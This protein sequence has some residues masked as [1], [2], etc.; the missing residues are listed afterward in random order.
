MSIEQYETSRNQYGGNVL[1]GAKASMNVGR[2][3]DPDADDE[4]L[5][6]LNQ[7]N[8]EYVRFL[9]PQQLLDE[10]GGYWGFN[11]WTQTFSLI[12]LIQ[13]DGFLI[14]ETV[15]KIPIVRGL[16]GLDKMHFAVAEGKYL[17]RS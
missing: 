9:Q 10:P 4:M 7:L 6:Y 15:E 3:V 11:E 5:G 16:L 14:D 17:I 13:H 1:T 12:L 2:L 8:F